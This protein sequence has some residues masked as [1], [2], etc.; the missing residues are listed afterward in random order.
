VQ[1]NHQQMK[2]SGRLKT[3]LYKQYGPWALITGASS[4]IGLELSRL[5]AESGLNLVINARNEAALINVTNT[6]SEH[7]PVEIK[8]VAADVSQQQGIDKLKQETAALPIGLLVAAAGYGSSGQFIQSEPETERNML[9]VNCEAVLSLTHHFGQ[10]FVKQQR[11]GIILLSSMVGFQGAPY[12]AHYAATKAYVQT[13]AEGIHAELKPFGV[14]VLAVAPGPVQ[15]G[16]A[17]RANM[18]MPMALSTEQVGLPILKALG[19]QTTVF[20]GFLSKLLVYSLRL[21]PRWGKIKVMAKV[22]RGM[23]TRK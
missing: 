23:T 7:Y 5:L 2:I 14:D 15:T 10:R 6:L 11:G 17:N 12:T 9:H 13:L 3:H 18:V 8:V 20:P 19:K 1:Q 21:L 16:F 22:M 4:G